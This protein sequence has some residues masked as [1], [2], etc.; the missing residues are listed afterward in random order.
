MPYME[1][2]LMTLAAGRP[3]AARRSAGSV[4]D[5]DQ[6][7]LDD[8]AQVIQRL[9][10]DRAVVADPGVVDGHVEPAQWVQAVGQRLPVALI[11]DVAGRGVDPSPR[12]RAGWPRRSGRRAVAG[13]SAPPGQHAREPRAEPA[14]APVTRATRP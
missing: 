1:A 14:E 2:T 6:V 4:Q 13:T 8:P 5:A 10:G 7:D 3:A 9:V 12:S 11:G